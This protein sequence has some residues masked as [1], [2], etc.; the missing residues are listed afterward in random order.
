MASTPSCVKWKRPDLLAGVCL[1]C[2]ID[3]QARN[4]EIDTLE[5][6][7]YAVTTGVCRP[8]IDKFHMDSLIGTGWE[9]PFT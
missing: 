1:Y 3:V 7:G 9:L 8:C 2:E 5:A 4:T 6:A